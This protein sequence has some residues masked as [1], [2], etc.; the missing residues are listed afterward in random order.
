ML[1]NGTF[2]LNGSVVH[3]DGTVVQFDGLLTFLR[4]LPEEQKSMLIIQS[5]RDVPHEQIV[6]V[7]DI[8]KEA[9]ID[10]IG[11]AV[12]STEDKSMESDKAQEQRSKDSD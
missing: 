2:V 4:N 9:G 7:M 6:K 8:A 5:E 12:S 11:L 10:K 1:L 3:L